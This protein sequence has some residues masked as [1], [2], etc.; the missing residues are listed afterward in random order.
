MTHVFFEDGKPVPKPI[1]MI[2]HESITQSWLKDLGTYA[3]VAGLIGTGAMLG[4][5][6]L[7]ITGAIMAAIVM[8]AQAGRK[9]NVQECFTVEEARAVLDQIEGGS[10]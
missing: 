5:V 3:T 6:T 9:H 10:K 1:I 8:I 2:V 7:Q 4:S